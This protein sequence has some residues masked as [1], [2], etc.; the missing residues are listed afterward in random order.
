MQMIGEGELETLKGA[1]YLGDIQPFYQ[2]TGC[3]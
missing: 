1:T 3:G 2:G